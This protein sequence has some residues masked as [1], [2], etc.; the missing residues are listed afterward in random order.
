M[1]H[2]LESRNFSLSDRVLMK[3]ERRPESGWCGGGG[4]TSGG[5]QKGRERRR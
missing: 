4:G 3:V 1:D 5:L 2:D